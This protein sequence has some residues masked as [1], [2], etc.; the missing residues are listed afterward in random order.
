MSTGD[1]SW[2][3]EFSRGAIAGVSVAV[4]V[5]LLVLAFMCSQRY[6]N[7]R[8]NAAGDA[9]ERAAAAAFAARPRAQPTSPTSA[10]RY[11]DNDDEEARRRR[12][13]R[14][15]R[16]SPAANLPSFT[17]NLSV[18]HN[19]TTGG[20][21]E[22]AAATCS[23]CLGAFQV[24]E[25]VRLLPVCLHLYHVDCIDPWLE[26][27]STCPICR[28]GTDLTIDGTL[29]LP[30]PPAPAPWRP[31]N[32]PTNNHSKSPGGIIAG[33][34]IAV[35]IILFLISCMCSLAKS[36]RQ[37][38]GNTAAQQ[39]A[40]AAAAIAARP[41]APPEP[42]DLW[43]N[44]DNDDQRPRSAHNDD[45]RRRRSSRTADLPSFTYSG[46]VKHNVTGT[47]DEPAATCSVCLGAFQVGEK[48]RLL[49]VCLHLYHVQ[50]IDPW[51]DVHSTCPICRSGTDHPA[52][53]GSLLPPV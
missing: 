39:H 2:S 49:P 35:G 9:A 16:A 17:Y 51:L 41:S 20:G 13:R 12:A 7:G 6:R 33:V 24:G 36:Q 1:D 53:D 25:T 43:G 3:S 18:K 5:I 22:D 52:M 38:D 48:V 14:S 28:S 15:R 47:G 26:V 27:H 4:G 42:A 44:D 34:S 10:A 50:C 8:V 46:S 32:S 45:S 30:Q 37:N 23:V 11:W 21:G 31:P 40:A 19:V 29:P